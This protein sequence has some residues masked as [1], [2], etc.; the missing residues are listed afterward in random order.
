MNSV[1]QYNLKHLQDKSSQFLY[2]IDY[3]KQKLIPCSV[4]YFNRTF[5]GRASGGITDRTIQR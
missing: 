3:S 4:G 5:F 1:L 2:L